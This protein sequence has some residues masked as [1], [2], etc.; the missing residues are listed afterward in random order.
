PPT[1]PPPGRGAPPPPL[2]RPR[3]AGAGRRGAAAVLDQPARRARIRDHRPAVARRGHF[4]EL[5]AH[6]LIDADG[7][8]LAVV[9]R[10]EPMNGRITWGHVV[11]PLPTV[12]SAADRP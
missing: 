8:G 12:F 6:F 10:A 7:N 3:S 5:D 11:P 2:V 4:G 9:L 1:P